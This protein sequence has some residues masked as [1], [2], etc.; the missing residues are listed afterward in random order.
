VLA[1]EAVLGKMTLRDVQF[2]EKLFFGQYSIAY[3]KHGTMKSY[4]PAHRLDYYDI[5]ANICTQYYT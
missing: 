5:H 4:G 2:V 3:L 1:R